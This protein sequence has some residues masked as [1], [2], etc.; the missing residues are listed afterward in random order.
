MTQVLKRVTIDSDSPLAM[1]IRDERT[2]RLL[3]RLQ[4][5]L[6]GLRN[7]T[8]RGISPPVLEL[9]K[10]DIEYCRETWEQGVLRG[11]HRL[12]DLASLMC[13]RLTGTDNLQHVARVVMGL[14]EEEEAPGGARIVIEEHITRENLK[15]YTD[16][17]LASRIAR[18]YRY[19]P[20][21]DQPLGV[22]YPRAS[23]LEL[24][25]LTTLEESPATRVLT[26][27]KT[28]D[29]IWNKVC[30]ALFAIDTLI[31]R[32][33]MLNSRSKYVKDVFGI[34][35]LTPRKSDSYRVDKILDG[36]AWSMDELTDAGLPAEVGLRKLE[37]FERKDYLSLPQDQKKRTGWEAIKNVYRW[38][39]HLFEVQIQTEANYFLEALHLTDTS[40]RTFEMQRRQM[41]RELELVVPHYAEFRRL[42]KLLF[43]RDDDEL[44][45]LEQ[46]LAWL[47]IV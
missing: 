11:E 45:E 43:R 23:F 41:R 15:L 36:L 37:L 3:Y 29:Q 19:R 24:W 1:L 18:R 38:G 7:A 33:K 20:S 8:A 32:D 9:A 47:T 6:E 28:N 46:A 2:N 42:L 13:R 10:K 35:I 22:L 12:Y 21:H 34:K 4:Q 44:D 25:P 31:E 17:T 39:G 14:K 26:R 30:D 27:V 5:Q 40:H 16:F